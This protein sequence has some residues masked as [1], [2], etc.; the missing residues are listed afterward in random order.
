MKI[1][2]AAAALAILCSFSA[3]AGSLQR[4]FRVGAIVVASATV[5]TALVKGQSHDAVDVRTGGYR[6]PPA[7]LLVNGEVKPLSDTN[8]ASLAALNEGRAVVT[9]VY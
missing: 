9:I 7:A 4:S 2:F 8:G 3:A 5:Q 6:A 1:S